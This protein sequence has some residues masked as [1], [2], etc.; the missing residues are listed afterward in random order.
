MIQTLLQR[1]TQS[2]DLSRQEAR[3]AMLLLMQGQASPP[4]IAALLIALRMKG[5]T[6][7]EVTGF[8]EAMR[9]LATRVIT[10]RKPLVDTCG[11][12]GDR[13]NT[14]NI[15]TAAA[16]VAAGAGVAVAKHGNR[17]ATSK[18]GS[19][20]VLE[21]LGVN[22]DVD[23]TR[24]GRCIDEVGIGFLF[25]RALHTA[26]KHVAPVR[27]EIKGV[28]TV[29]NLLGPLTNPAGACGQVMGVFDKTWLSP[30]AEVLKNLGTR[31]AFVVA[32]AD[33]L[34]EFTLTTH[35]LVAEARKD[36]V[37]TYEITPEQLG[38][39]R[40]ERGA[41]IGGDA[42]DNARILLEVFDGVPGPRR[43]IV[44]LNAA[45]AIL[46]GDAASDWT[47]AI[48][49]ANAAIDSGAAREKLESLIKV[50]HDS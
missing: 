28:P 10:H 29:F 13:S 20:D 11:T 33:G 3:D 19:A 32:G 6:V 12:G 24:V 42:M 47:E 27:Q 39:K 31:H 38:F 35:T 26:M 30:L 46:V 8:A 16:F 2:G 40:C 1:L 4:Q 9:E 43:D 34:D 21:A 36:S 41:L 23:A 15:S 48:A 5:E 37:R 7:E 44:V 22:V 25:A 14:F 50:T 45:A 17:S 49:K 18:C